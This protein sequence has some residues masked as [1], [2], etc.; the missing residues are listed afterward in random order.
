MKIGPDGINMN[1][2]D[3]KFNADSKTITEI[4]NKEFGPIEFVSQLI[5]SEASLVLGSRVVIYT[6]LMRKQFGND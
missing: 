2:Y 6:H 4:L 3:I 1:L 5:D